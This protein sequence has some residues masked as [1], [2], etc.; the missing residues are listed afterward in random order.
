MKAVR[1]AIPAEARAR[2]AAAVA[3]HAAALE[4]AAHDVV[5]AFWPMGEEI[6][7][8]PAMEALHARGAALALPTVA[9]RDKPL[10]FRR[11]R[12]GDPLV[13]AGFG[14]SEPAPDAA[15]VT[16][17]VLLV[18][19]LAFTRAGARLGYGGGF[20]DRTIAAIAAASGRAPRTIGVGY[21]AQEV[22][23][24]PL[25]TH[26]E[27]LGA[28]LT[29]SGLRPADAPAGGARERRDPPPCD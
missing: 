29:E 28:L 19:L 18:P 27:P 9:G 7:V 5:S 10:V 6:D 17:T 2:A 15:A 24:L 26:D 14:T 4:L 20:Y 25:E 23:S 8:R 22:E 16:P 12:P 3:R 1:A 21:D 11:Y 13:P